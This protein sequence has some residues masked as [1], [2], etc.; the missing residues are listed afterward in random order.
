MLSGA[1]S[2]VAPLLTGAE[3][4]LAAPEDDY[5]ALHGLYWAC[6]NLAERR[7]LVL[8][9]DDAQWADERSLRFLHFL[10]RRLEGL[11]ILLLIAVRT[12]EPGAPVSLLE[13]IS[14]S[15]G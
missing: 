2:L 7:P 3:A 14:G 15:P 4:A 6:A 8:L 13:R 11:P 9:V 10:A 12:F 5:A 1:A